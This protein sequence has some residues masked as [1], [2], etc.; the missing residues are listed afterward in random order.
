MIS[1]SS[2]GGTIMNRR[3]TFITGMALLGLAI[4]VPQPVF[5]QSSP[6]VGTWQLNLAKSK[7]SPGPAVS[8]TLNLQTEGQN[9]KLTFTGTDANGK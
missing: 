9:L 6:F 8:G 4:A 3:T 2:Q 5:A 7:F 1:N